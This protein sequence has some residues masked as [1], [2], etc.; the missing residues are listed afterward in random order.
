MSKLPPI[1]WAQREESLY[2]TIDIP[3]VDEKEAKISL[4]ST[5]IDFAGKSGGDDY[6]VTIELSSEIDDKSEDSKWMVKGRNVQFYLK[7]K[8]EGSWGTLLKDKQLQ[9]G[10]R[11][12]CP[13]R[14]ASS[15][16]EVWDTPH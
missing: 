15:G 13:L 14:L 8:E 12:P 1:K 2:V 9:V 11:A 10:R 16:A 3:D 4:T 6:S 7:K 5:T